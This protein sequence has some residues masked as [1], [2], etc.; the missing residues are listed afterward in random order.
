MED[1][2]AFSAAFGEGLSQPDPPL[3]RLGVIELDSSS[4]QD[5]LDG[6]DPPGD[7][8][9]LSQPTMLASALEA[10]SYTHLTL[11]TIC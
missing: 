7:Q 5:A 3:R 8:P 2:A 10:V 6:M 11:P 4:Q 9:G 1:D